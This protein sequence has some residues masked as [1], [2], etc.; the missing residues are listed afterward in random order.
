MRGVVVSSTSFGPRAKV[1]GTRLDVWLLVDALNEADATKESVAEYFGTPVEV[2]D[3]AVEYHQEFPD[4]V[5]A[6]R[7]AYLA[8][9]ADAAEHLPHVR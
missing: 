9:A 7:Q 3:A 8:A 6:E 4:R 1:E 2:V 5:T